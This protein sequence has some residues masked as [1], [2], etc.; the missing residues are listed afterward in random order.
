[1][2]SRLAHALSV[3]PMFYDAIQW[4]VGSRTCYAHLRATLPPT[5]GKRVLDVGGGTGISRASL[6][7]SAEYVVADLDP[8]KLVLLRRKE[9]AAIAVR[10][11]ASRLPARARSFDLGL[12]IFVS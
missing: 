5:V 12:L 3:R 7:S 9:P 1:M 10:A 8:E 11:D 2:L 4:A 6:D